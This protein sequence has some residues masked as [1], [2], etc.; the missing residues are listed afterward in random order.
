MGSKRRI[1]K[2]ILPI[3]LNEAEKNNITKWIE[4]FVG[5]ANV[6]SKVP[7]NYERIGYDVNKYLIALYNHINNY[8]FTF[9]ENI[10]KQLYSDV[11]DY[12]NRNFN[13]ENVYDDAFIGWVGFMASANGRFFDGGYSGISKTKHG[14]VRNYISESIRGLKKEAPLLTNIDFRYSCYSNLSFNNALIYCDPPYANVKQYSNFNF[15]KNIFIEWCKE[16]SK[17]NIVFVSEYE[18]PFKCIWQKELKNT[19]LSNASI[20][21]TKVGLEKL[22]LVN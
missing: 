6:I 8:G 10:S 14:T 20:S 19:L 18:L 2:D 1:L 12:Y 11:R 15:D 4:P 16:Q 3:M 13:S 22:Y 17:N 5:G 7:T 21:G 9:E